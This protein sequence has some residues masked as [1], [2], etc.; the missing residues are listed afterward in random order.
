MIDQLDEL[1]ARLKASILQKPT[2][3]EI[4]YFM[5]KIVERTKL[6]DELV[7]MRAGK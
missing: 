4:D 3:I 7:K 5:E 1:I 6:N 2:A